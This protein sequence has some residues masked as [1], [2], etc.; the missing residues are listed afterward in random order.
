M[1]KTKSFTQ[2]Y[3]ELLSE[4]EKDDE[5]EAEPVDYEGKTEFL[6]EQIDSVFAEIDKIINENE[7]T[8]KLLLDDIVT[9]ND[10]DDELSDDNDEK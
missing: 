5:D 7:D 4:A 1:E 3:F 6:N 10:I 8:D 2:R 9:E